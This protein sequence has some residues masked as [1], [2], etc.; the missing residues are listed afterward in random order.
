MK[1][2]QLKEWGGRDLPGFGDEAT[3][4][5]RTPTIDD[6]EP[7]DPLAD[8]FRTDADELN[9]IFIVD[10]GEYSNDDPEVEAQLKRDGYRI[11]NDTGHSFVAAFS[12]AQK[13][14]YNYFCSGTE[15]RYVSMYVVAE[16]KRLAQEAG[17]KFTITD[18]QRLNNKWMQALL[19]Q[20]PDV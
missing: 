1:L 12:H 8:Y 3:W 13:P 19:S 17:K 9:G 20:Q 16:L 10:P 15:D 5:G 11:E 7:E 14:V 18:L 4:G 2:K 6:D